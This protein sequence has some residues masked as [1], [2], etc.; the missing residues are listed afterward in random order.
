MDFQSD[1]WN[2]FHDGSIVEVRGEL[3]NISLRVEIQYLR[4]KLPGAGDSIWIHLKNC[5]LIR[6]TAWESE[7]ETQLGDINAEHDF[8]ILNAKTVDDSIHIFSPNGQLELTYTGSNLELD[9]GHVISW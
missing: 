6:L 2:S 4:E 8:E 9:S 7:R 1:L 3:P 5:T